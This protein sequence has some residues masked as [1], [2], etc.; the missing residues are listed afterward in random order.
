M[1]QSAGEWVEELDTWQVL[2]VM[3][4]LDQ[5]FHKFVSGSAGEPD[6]SDALRGLDSSLVSS[7]CSNAVPLW[8]G[9]DYKMV[10]LLDV[11]ICQLH[12]IDQGRVIRH[13]R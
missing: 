11:S 7:M 4:N 5:V 1:D 6:L 9:W 10:G 13:D 3:H 8:N 12:G 2:G